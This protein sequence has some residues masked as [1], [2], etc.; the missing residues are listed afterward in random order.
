MGKLRIIADEKD[1]AE[2]V[3]SAISAELKRLEIALN[4]T[5]KEIRK[6]EE[7]YK[8]PSGVFLKEFTAEDLRGGD[9]EYIR[10]TGELKIR[11]QVL[12]DLKRLK[13]VEYVSN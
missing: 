1:T 6:F 4:K 8:I 3:K 10:W 7:E 13:D 11:E 12:E 2:I 5:D 9:E